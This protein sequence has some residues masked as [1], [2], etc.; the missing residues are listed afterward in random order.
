MRSMAESAE[1]LGGR[2]ERG[3]LPEELLL[4]TCV[5]K[6]PLLLSWVSM[7]YFMSDSPV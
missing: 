1:L 2:L 4:R 7:K 3:E 5:G 6:V